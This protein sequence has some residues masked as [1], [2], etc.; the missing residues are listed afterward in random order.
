MREASLQDAQ[1]GII[2]IGNGKAAS[3]E[4]RFLRQPPDLQ[5]ERRRQNTPPLP[6][7]PRGLHKVVF[8]FLLFRPGSGSV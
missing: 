5:E 7:A 2:L 4:E 6:S 3:R 8:G 1:R